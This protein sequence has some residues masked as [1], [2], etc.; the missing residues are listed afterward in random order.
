M[1]QALD[2]IRAVMG[3]PDMDDAQARHLLAVALQA[4]IDPLLHCAIVGGISETLAMERAAAWTG[5]PFFEHVPQGLLG[6]IEPT[7]L[8][9]LAGMRLFR[10]QVLDRAVDFTAPDFVG[11]LRLKQRLA[12]NPQLH[13]RICL[14]PASALRDYVTVAAAPELITAARQGLAQ[15]WPYAAAQ[16]ELTAPARYGFALGVILLLAMAL[17][18]PFVA[19]FWLCPVALALLVAP[20]A[21]RVAAVGTTPRPLPAPRRPPDPELPVYSVLIPLRNEAAMVPQLFAA[22]WALDYP[23]ARLDVKFIV[24]AGCQQTIAAIGPRLGD[25]RVALVVVP[26]AAPRT[27]PKALDFALPL[28]RG[29]HV[30]V[31]DAEDI[32]DTD[33]LWQ[34]ALR[35]RDQPDLVCLQARLLVDNGNHSWLAALFAAEYA[36]LFAVLLPALA[37]WH[38]PL[39]LGGS[40]NHFR[41]AI[42]RQIGGWDAFNVTE[43]ADLGMRLARRRLRVETLDCNTREHAPLRLRNWR[44]QRTRWMKGWMQTFIVHNRN[45]GRL[46]A[47]MGLGP[48]LV[49]EVLVL[50]M[51]VA[52][53][54][55]CGLVI[56]LALQLAFGAPLFDGRGWSVFYSG[57]LGLGFGSTVAITLLGLARS[58]GL[59]L[60]LAQ[61]LLPFY[62]LLIATATLSA[63]ADL[64]RRPFYWFKT[65]HEPVASNQR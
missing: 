21:I 16:L 54:L 4:E 64:L 8:E 2:L 47:E 40:S 6:R 26:D 30:V 48:T 22:I 19:E 31:F 12:S 53:L 44:G 20:A 37:R 9:D 24:E 49:F 34:A 32:P 61:L 63:L 50:G 38:L 45:P 36:A 42:L 11:L 43:D 1:S 39:P 18:A 35:F 13:R 52:P 59:R 56:G 10:M 5:F 23:P 60:A 62:W 28:C 57:V 33:Q 17:L 41:T 29:E 58:G 55:H 51:I 65:P 15:R 14:L 46:V 25:P 7:Q 27:K 3:A